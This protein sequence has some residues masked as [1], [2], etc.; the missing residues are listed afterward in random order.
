[1]ITV[2]TRRLWTSAGLCG[3][4]AAAIVAGW[5][6]LRTS[7]NAERLAAGSSAPA[8][9]STAAFVLASAPASR[10]TRPEP[11]TASDADLIRH[12]QD[13]P[14]DHRAWAI[15][16]R[17]EARAERFDAAAASYKAALSGR[18]KVARDPDVWVEYAEALAMS[19]GGNLAG[20][21][22]QHLNR[23][24]SLQPDHPGA[25]DLVAAAA[26]D[27]GDFDL[28]AAQW[29]RL[30]QQFSANDPRR[31]GVQAAIERAQRQARFA[32]PRRGSQF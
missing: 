22:L 14:S 6:A 28:A 26:W 7:A 13:Y 27:A 19:R 9:P 4:V 30:M 31:A 5:G 25:L 20:E 2:K 1:M 29:K 24:L 18:S 11:V 17:L 15:K 23:A 10:V 21:P 3:L 16:A 32:A 8:A 12:L